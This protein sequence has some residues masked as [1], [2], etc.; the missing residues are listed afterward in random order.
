MYL[1]HFGFREKPFELSP[2]PR[3]LYLS[4]QHEEALTALKYGIWQRRGLIRLTGAVGTGKSTL[5]RALMENLDVSIQTVWIHHT[6]LEPIEFLR[7]V[8]DDLGIESASND[9]VDLIHAAHDFLVTEAAA[10]RPAP[11]LLV[12]EAQNLSDQVLEEIRLLS[13]V[14]TDQRKLLQVVLAGQPELER[15]LDQE[16]LRNFAQRIAVRAW[17]QPMGP[18]DTHEYIQHR[19]SRAGSTDPYLFN[20]EVCRLI[21]EASGGVPRRINLVAEQCLVY[22]YAGGDPRVELAIAKEAIADLEVRSPEAAVEVEASES[23]PVQARVTHSASF[24]VPRADPRVE[25][26][27][28]AVLLLWVLAL[29]ASLAG[30]W[31][32]ANETLAWIVRVVLAIGCLVLPF[33]LGLVGPRRRK[34]RAWEGGLPLQTIPTEREEPS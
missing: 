8:V 18:E 10:S 32:A 33:F 30:D 12:D 22:T 20:A 26:N 27:S 4:A 5:I 17:L 7:M 13:N 9:R 11:V 29:A 31:G 1:A 19:L 14:E 28:V 24:E 2:D 15:R 21:W 16:H 23:E 6:T 3:Y 34:P 25:R